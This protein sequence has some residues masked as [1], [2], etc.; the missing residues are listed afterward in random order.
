MSDVMKTSKFLTA[1]EWREKGQLLTA[2]DKDFFT[3]DVGENDNC[4]VLLHGYLTSSYDYYKVIDELSK[5]YRVIAHDLIGFGFSDK[6]TDHYFSISD[7]VDCLLDLW[8]QIGIDNIT[9]LA[10]DYGTAIAQEILARKNADLCPINVKEL[11]YCNG[12]LPIKESHFLDTQ[13]FLKKEV[14]KKLI[15]ML[16][17]FGIYKKTM[18][19]VFC[20]D[21]KITDE[22][23][24]EM[25]YL[26]EYN[27]GRDVI[28]FIYNY[29]RER[30]ILWGRWVNALQDTDVLLKV[31]WSKNDPLVDEN[32]TNHL[33]KK[34]KNNEIHWI[35]NS[36][37]FPMLETPEAWLKAVLSD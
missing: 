29:L 28:S 20:D 5:K 19:E 17:S 31:V 8:K 12:N 37:H 24:S 18:R 30:K 34:T 22:E 11:I 1:S 14:A 10:H 2:F 16:A 7:Q 15:G 4:L 9:L 36:G 23:L 32:F 33:S 21:S 26:L 6:T 25:W 35:E 27:H 3:I 13:E